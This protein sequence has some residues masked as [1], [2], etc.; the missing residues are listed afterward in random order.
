MKLIDKILG[1]MQDV[2]STLEK[3]RRLITEKKAKLRAIEH[4]PVHRLRRL[5][6][7]T[8]ISSFMR[9]GIAMDCG[10]EQIRRTSNFLAPGCS[11]AALRRQIYFS[12]YV[13]SLIRL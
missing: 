4:I 1:P 11:T 9:K 6:K 7:L 2:R 10:Q 3:Q 13:A 5:R 8:L 12:L